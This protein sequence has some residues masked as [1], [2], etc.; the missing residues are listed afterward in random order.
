M[1][2]VEERRRGGAAREEAAWGAESRGSG[3]PDLTRKMASHS[4][5]ESHVGSVR[6]R[7][8]VAKRKGVYCSTDDSVVLKRCAAPLLDYCKAHARLGTEADSSGRQG[9]GY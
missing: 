1:L 7:R 5:V 2:H 6:G 4:G 8:A 3:V 9:Q